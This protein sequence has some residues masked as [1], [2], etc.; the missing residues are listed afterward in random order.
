VYVLCFMSIAL[1]FVNRQTKPP[2]LKIKD[3]KWFSIFFGSKS[4]P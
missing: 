1:R 2:S 4:V 3:L